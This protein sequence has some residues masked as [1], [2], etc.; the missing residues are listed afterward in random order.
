MRVNPLLELGSQH[1]PQAGTL[2]QA[3]T[4]RTRWY[5]LVARTSNQRTMNIRRNHTTLIGYPYTLDRACMPSRPNIVRLNPV[6]AGQ[7]TSSTVP[8]AVN[9]PVVGCFDAIVR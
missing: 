8:A 4:A 3:A 1:L 6:R 2:Y 7:R 9:T 5:N